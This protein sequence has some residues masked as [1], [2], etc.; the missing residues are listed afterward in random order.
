[1]IEI[2]NKVRDVLQA[3]AAE[4]V[5]A[6]TTIQKNAAI[7]FPSAKIYLF[8]VY[9]KQYTGVYT[10]T[11]EQV[12]STNW[13]KTD[14][15]EKLTAGAAGYYDVL[16]LFE[17]S[18]LAKFER[19]VPT[20]F[21]AW[22]TTDSGGATRYIGVPIELLWDSVIRVYAG[23][24]VYAKRFCQIYQWKSGDGDGVTPQVRLPSLVCNSLAVHGEGELLVPVSDI[25]ASNYGFAYVGGYPLVTPASN[26]VFSVGDSCGSDSSGYLIPCGCATYMGMVSSD[27]MIKLGR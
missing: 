27:A 25:T 6:P 9:A 7:R 17:H 14:G 24:D 1:M 16:N 2:F 18:P 3:A 19:P 23:A 11:L 15:S 10:C 4:R 5:A 26:T 20:H 21:V 13:T 8:K 12:Y 22:Q